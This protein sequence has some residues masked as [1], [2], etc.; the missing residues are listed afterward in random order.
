MNEIPQGRT[1]EGMPT[2]FT[3]L[4]VVMKAHTRALSDK[5]LEKLSKLGVPT[6]KVFTK[7]LKIEDYHQNEEIVTSKYSAARY[8]IS[9]IRDD[10]QKLTVK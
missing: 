3:R 9:I 5:N 8:W 1:R 2:S 4:G 7:D 6:Y 10:G